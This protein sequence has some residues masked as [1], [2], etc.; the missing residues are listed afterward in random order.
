MFIGE[1]P[2]RGRGWWHGRDAL[3][4]LECLIP[5]RIRQEALE[6]RAIFRACRNERVTKRR[7][8][9]HA[10]ELQRGK[11]CSTKDPGREHQS[12]LLVHP[13]ERLRATQCP[14]ELGSGTDWIALDQ[15]FNPAAQ[16]QQARLQP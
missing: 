16:V 2:A 10:F 9:L 3:D 14:Y 5:D 15:R 13:C 4:E 11:S 7:L 1:R 6:P 8:L 12:N